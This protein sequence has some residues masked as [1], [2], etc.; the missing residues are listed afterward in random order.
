VAAGYVAAATSVQRVIAR[1]KP[2][3]AR[4]RSRAAGRLLPT[5][6]RAPS[7]PSNMWARTAANGRTNR[8]L[9]TDAIGDLASTR[10]DLGSVRRNV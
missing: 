2:V 7:A 9:A 6:G 8:P 3:R 10:R 5:I 1:S 4:A